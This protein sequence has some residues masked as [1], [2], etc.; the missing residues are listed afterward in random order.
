MKATADESA[1]LKRRLRTLPAT[2]ALWAEAEA[3]PLETSEAIEEVERH[4]IVALPGSYVDTILKSPH[5]V[6]GRG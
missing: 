1:N 6:G 5:P 4:L 3:F 2:P